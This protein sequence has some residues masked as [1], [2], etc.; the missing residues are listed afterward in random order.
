[1]VGLVS[2]HTF[3]QTSTRGVSYWKAQEGQD[4]GMYEHHTFRIREVTDLE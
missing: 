1:M 4:W 3:A 2:S